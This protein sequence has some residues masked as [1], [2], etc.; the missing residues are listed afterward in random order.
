V[1][2]DRAKV[3]DAPEEQF[4][5]ASGR[6]QLGKVLMHA[7]DAAA[8]GGGFLDQDDLAAGVGEFDRG[9]EAGDRKP[10]KEE[11]ATRLAA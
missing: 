5:P 11:T 2:R 10:P 8:E 6:T 4:E 1:H 9:G 3:A 7:G